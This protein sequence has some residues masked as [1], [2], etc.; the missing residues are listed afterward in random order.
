MVR[1]FLV[2]FLLKMEKRLLKKVAIIAL[3]GGVGK[4]TL[5]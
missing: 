2:Y 1:Y 4:S 5:R 3:K